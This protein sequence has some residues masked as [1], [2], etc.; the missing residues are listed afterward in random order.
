MQSQYDLNLILNPTLSGEQ[1]Q[2]EKD[3]ISN[4]VQNLEPK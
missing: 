3:Y 4:A 2:T 1:L